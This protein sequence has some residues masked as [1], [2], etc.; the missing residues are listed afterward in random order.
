MPHIALHV[1]V[2]VE[3]R[4]GCFMP[5]LLHGTV[6]RRERFCVCVCVC[7]WLQV[8]EMLTTHTHTAHTAHTL[9]NHTSTRTLRGTVTGLPSSPG[10]EISKVSPNTE[11]SSLSSWS[12]SCWRPRAISGAAVDKSASVSAFSARW[13]VEEDT[14]N[15]RMSVTLQLALGH[16]AAAKKKRTKKKPQR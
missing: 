9:S 10:T 7:V 16:E 8:S 2:L 4:H 11:S 1:V 14:N 12:S 13:K 3:K 15:K 5:V 6:R